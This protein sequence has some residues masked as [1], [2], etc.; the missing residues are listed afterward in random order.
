MVAVR[1]LGLKLSPD[2]IQA[3]PDAT[4]SGDI[5]QKSIFDRHDY[6]LDCANKRLMAYSV[7]L[8]LRKGSC[9]QTEEYT[10]KRYWKTILGP[11]CKIRDL[12]GAGFRKLR[13][14]VGAH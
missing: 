8:P 7:T 3:A 14:P 5:R 12:S 1:R 13:V 4:G 6:F 2:G 9:G 11:S 10:M